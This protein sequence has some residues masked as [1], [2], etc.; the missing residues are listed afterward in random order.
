MILARCAILGPAA[1]VFRLK[2]FKLAARKMVA[3]KVSFRTCEVKDYDKASI[4]VNSCYS[5]RYP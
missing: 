1:A 4:I 2:H 5:V 3:I